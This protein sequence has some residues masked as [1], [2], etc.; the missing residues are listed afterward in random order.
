MGVTGKSEFGKGIEKGDVWLIVLVYFDHKHHIIYT[1]QALYP[2]SSRL[3]HMY[4]VIIYKFLKQT[5]NLRYISMLLTNEHGILGHIGWPLY[6][7]L[8][9][10]PKSEIWHP[11]PHHGGAAPGFNCHP[12]LQA[13]QWIQ[14]EQDQ[15]QNCLQ[16]QFLEWTI[17]LILAFGDRIHDTR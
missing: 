11:C 2:T 4:E 9:Q 3:T 17:F 14:V 12:Y 15:Q 8:L 13:I 16:N 10:E 5:K 7:G 1:I 6:F